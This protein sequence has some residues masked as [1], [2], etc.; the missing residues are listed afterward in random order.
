MACIPITV[1]ALPSL[2]VAEAFDVNP[3]TL[4][5]G[6]TFVATQ[7]VRNTGGSSGIAIVDFREGGAT[8][9]IID[10]KQVTVPAGAS[11]TVTSIT[12]IADTVGTTSICATLR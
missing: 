10:T 6:N 11:V 9:T 3:K 8:G 2:I 12:F 1:T 7:V 4:Q 5:V